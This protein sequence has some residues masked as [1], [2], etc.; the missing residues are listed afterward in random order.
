MTSAGN[1]AVGETTPFQLY[2]VHVAVAG[3]ARFARRRIRSRIFANPGT[4]LRSGRSLP[5]HRERPESAL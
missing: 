1:S 3:R 5:D 2:G 4:W